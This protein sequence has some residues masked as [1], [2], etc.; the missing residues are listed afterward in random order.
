MRDSVRGTIAEPVRAE[1]YIQVNIGRNVRGEEMTMI[2][3][4]DFIDEVKIAIRRS[5]DDRNVRI[6][7]HQGVG[8]WDGEEEDSA[9]LSAF[10]V[11]DL[12]ELRSELQ[13]IA[14]YHD[15]DSIALIVRSELIRA[16]SPLL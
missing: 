15:Q 7:E 3:W 2:K 14:Y 12:S 8:V 5:A 13:R 9:H 11:F 1:R 10:G 16:K 6:E 4:F